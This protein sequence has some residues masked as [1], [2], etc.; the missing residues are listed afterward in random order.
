LALSLTLYSPNL[1]E[2]GDTI[3]TRGDPDR[4]LNFLTGDQTL[5]D[6]EELYAMLRIPP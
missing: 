6:P 2:A 3:Y 4:Y 5:P 1:V